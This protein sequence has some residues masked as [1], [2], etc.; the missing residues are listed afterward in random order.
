M[1]NAVGPWDVRF[2]EL[3]NHVA[4][5]SKD[6]KKKVGAVLVGDSKKKI[7][8]GYNGFPPGVKDY[9]S[10]LNSDELKFKM[11]MH[12]ERN[13][14]DNAFFEPHTLYTT[15][16]LCP[17]CAGTAISKGVVRVVQPLLDPRS[18]WADEAETAT[19][20]LDEAGVEL[21][22]YDDHVWE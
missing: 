7:A 11:V 21:A 20:M 17:Q 6:P 14:L 10:R 16:P 2:L 22:I 1:L 18:D 15:K 19:M 12:A 4:G 5:W 13:V 8:L 3:A 9:L